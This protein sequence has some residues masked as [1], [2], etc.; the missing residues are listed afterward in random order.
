VET[1]LPGRRITEYR[2]PA[3]PLTLNLPER[4]AVAQ[5][6]ALEYF[7]T[8]LNIA[9]L[10]EVVVGYAPL[11][12]QIINNDV[13]AV[14]GGP[15]KYGVSPETQQVVMQ[16]IIE[17]VQPVELYIP[18]FADAHFGDTFATLQGTHSRAPSCLVDD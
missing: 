18:P 5:R 13:V 4:S 11:P 15:S 3:N 1:A 8:C 16:F 12:P 7:C 14:E 10:P 17:R 9:I 2:S 6:Q